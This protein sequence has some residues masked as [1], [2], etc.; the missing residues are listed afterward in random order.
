M[1]LGGASRRQVRTFQGERRQ[2]TRKFIA[3]GL[4]VCAHLGYPFHEHGDGGGFVTVARSEGL[5]FHE[6]NRPPFFDLVT[7]SSSYAIGLYL[8]FLNS[9]VQALLAARPRVL[10]IRWKPPANETVRIQDFLSDPF[11]LD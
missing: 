10:S 6:K 8:D 3:V 7:P 4:L 9:G 5:G 1:D 11:F 2:K